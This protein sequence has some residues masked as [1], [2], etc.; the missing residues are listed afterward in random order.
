MNQAL[1]ADVT[2][3]VNARTLALAMRAS[4]YPQILRQRSKLD[5][6]STT[7]IGLI[8]RFNIF[9]SRHPSPPHENF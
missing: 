3:T 8:W 1:K 9:V 7:T 2:L 5:F 4:G 6:V